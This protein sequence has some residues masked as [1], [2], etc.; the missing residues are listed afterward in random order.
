MALRDRFS[1]QA[2]V[3]NARWFLAGKVVSA[4]ATVGWLALVTRSLL[5][6]G[7]LASYLSAIAYLETALALT[8]CGLDWLLI[9]HLPPAAAAG[10]AA[11]LRRLLLAAVRA[12][13]GL[14]FASLVL[15]GLGI[16][17]LGRPASLD[18]LALPLL[19]LLMLSEA[20]LRL[21][22]D[23]ALE[24]LA[25]QRYTQFGVLGRTLLA[26]AGLAVLRALGRDV[27]TNA[28]LALEATASLTM[29]GFSAHWVRGLLPPTS[30][31]VADSAPP[32]SHA[33]RAC[34]PNY[35]A[36]LISL[37]L[38]PQSL[39]LALSQLVP[40]AVLAPL[41]LALRVFEIL[42]NYVPGLLLMNVLRPRL[43]G[44]HAVHGDFAR[45]AAEAGLISRWSAVSVAPLVA[46]LAL[47]GDP[48]LAVFAGRALPA[49]LG[50]ML[51]LMAATLLLRV[52]RQIGQVLVNI[53]S[54]QGLLTRLALLGLL[55]WPLACWLA[56]QGRAT[57]A[58]PMALG[59][60]EAAW[61][62]GMSIG[63][64]SA[65]WTWPV[66]T[67]FMLGLLVLVA[68]SVLL[69]GAL[70]LPANLLGTLVGSLV[71]VPVVLLPAIRLGRLE[72]RSA[73]G[74]LRSRG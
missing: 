56:Q 48:A 2:T 43:I 32:F 9:R 35:L 17:C 5:Q 63:L 60:D 24:S 10:D 13:A 61:V 39:L 54:A 64:R 3:S 14:V 16:A 21:L 51:S 38:A 1:R 36:A 27:D 72:W 25:A 74:M 52:H 62:L 71:L 20:L 18:G 66:G 57:W 58:L 28:L 8:L 47:Y 65:G 29:L 4:L 40:A 69:V 68:M 34:W 23:T 46:W 53:V 45:T 67:T 31:A 15:L 44:G 37:P 11:G 59:W 70:P 42:R 6:Q 55:G 30:A 41:G 73:L 49:G 50:L 22:R 26:L 7:G 19:G 12:R 33:W